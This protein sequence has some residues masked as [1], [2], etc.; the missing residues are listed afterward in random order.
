MSDNKIESDFTFTIAYV[1]LGSN[2]LDNNIDKVQYLKAITMKYKKE[3]DVQD[4]SE[5]NVPCS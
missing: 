1:Y 4:I 3:E 5:R 2:M